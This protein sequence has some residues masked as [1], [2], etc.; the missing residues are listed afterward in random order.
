MKKKNH[1]CCDDGACDS[2]TCMG[3]PEGKTC[4]DCTSFRQC[5]SMIGVEETNTVCDFFPRRFRMKN[6][7]E[8]LKPFIVRGVCF[9][10]TT[11]EIKIKA[12]DRISAV[13]EAL[14]SDWR[15]HIGNDGDNASAFG[16]EPY[17]FEHKP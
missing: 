13:A 2:D 8:N 14:R 10:P 1:G 5:K 7:E 4:S 6:P 11:V 16:W 17:A 9:V 12:K 15:S 3:L